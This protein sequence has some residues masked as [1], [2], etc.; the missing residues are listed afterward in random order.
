MK[1][2]FV[3]DITVHDYNRFKA[4]ID[5]IPDIIARH[6]GKYIVQGVEPTCL[7]GE[8]THERLVI[9]EFPDRAHA[10]ALLSDPDA[11]HL[12]ELRHSTTTGRMLLAEGCTP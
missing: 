7:E 10:E 5:E 8:W 9:I 12:F 4:Y 2:Y 11:Q 1:A 3:L 6:R